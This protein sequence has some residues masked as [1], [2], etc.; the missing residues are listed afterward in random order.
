MHAEPS[1]AA[2]QS[3]RDRVR[4]L[5]RRHTTWKATGEIVSEINEA[6]RGWGH[7]FARENHHRSFA[8]MNHF[9]GGRLRQWLWRKPFRQAQD[10]RQAQSLR[11]PEPAEGHGNPVEKYQR[12]PDRDLFAKY[13]L[14]QLPTKLV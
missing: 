10:I 7:Y 6:S 5:T 9:I 1:P 13:G 2:E 14:H 12:W 11:G 4:E 8:Q 3:L